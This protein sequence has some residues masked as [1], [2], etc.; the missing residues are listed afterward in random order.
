MQVIERGVTLDLELAIT[1][2]SY[3]RRDHTTKSGAECLEVTTCSGGI[4]VVASVVVVRSVV[5]CGVVVVVRS[6]VSVVVTGVH[7]R[8]VVACSSVGVTRTSSSNRATLII[9]CLNS[10][11]V[12][13]DTE[14]SVESV[15]LRSS[16]GSCGGGGG[17]S[18][19][20]SITGSLVRTTAVYKSVA[21]GPRNNVDVLR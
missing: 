14:D 8:V 5:I 13:G 19:S 6:I 11:K 18:A 16:L 3:G 20:A 21:N 4:V 17:L 12:R 10:S 1:S 7:V 15:G 2:S 9:E